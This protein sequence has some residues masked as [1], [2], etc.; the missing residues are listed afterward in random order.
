MNQS[1]NQSP[2]PTGAGPHLLPSTSPAPLLPPPSLP[3]PPAPSQ[4]LILFGCARRWR[5]RNFSR[6]PNGALLGP[7]I[8]RSGFDECVH[9]YPVTAR[10]SLVPPTL[11]PCPDCKQASGCHV[12]LTI[13]CLPK[14]CEICYSVQTDSPFK[15][16]EQHD[17]SVRNRN[18]NSNK[19]SNRT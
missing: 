18:D 11:S 10:I 5:C 3:V 4:W 7:G 16:A 14:V 9:K 19:W 17:F 8:L 6:L 13:S 15:Q 2:T 1:Y 12:A